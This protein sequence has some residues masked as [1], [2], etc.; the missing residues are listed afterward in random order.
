MGPD[1]G[2][3]PSVDVGLP[4]DHPGFGEQGVD[5]PW[6]GSVQE[7]NRMWVG[8]VENYAM[9]IICLRPSSRHGTPQID[10]HRFHCMAL[11]RQFYRPS[12]SSRLAISRQNE[13]RGLEHS[14]ACAAYWGSGYPR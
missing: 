8:S 1:V 4:E 13:A 2:E 3:A 12:I 9:Q 6:S 5:G 14:E 11:M 7:G 10:V